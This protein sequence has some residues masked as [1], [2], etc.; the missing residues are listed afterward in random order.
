MGG[1]RRVISDVLFHPGEVLPGIGRINFLGRFRFYVNKVPVMVF[2]KVP[3]YGTTA[4]TVMLTV[5][6]LI[7]SLAVVFGNIEASVANQVTLLK[8]AL[9]IPSIVAVLT[10]VNIAGFLYEWVS[11]K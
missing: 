7:S 2:Y 9:L 5:V 8:P 10:I 1:Y 6:L 11:S 4:F 3:W